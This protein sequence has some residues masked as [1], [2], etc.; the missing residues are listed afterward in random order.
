MGF[1]PTRAEHNGLAVHRLNHSATSSRYRAESE[2]SVMDSPDE[3][4]TEQQEKKKKEVATSLSRYVIK[5]RR[6]KIPVLH[7]LLFIIGVNTIINPDD[8][9]ILTG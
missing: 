6:V 9:I 4:M 5:S 8:I 7:F 1:E 2:H 3:P